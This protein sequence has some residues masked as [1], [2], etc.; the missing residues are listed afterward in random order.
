MEGGPD[1]PLPYVDN[2]RGAYT[3]NASERIGENA[4]EYRDKATP[5][6]PTH[7]LPTTTSRLST[8]L[9]ICHAIDT[10]IYKLLTQQAR[11]DLGG[12]PGGLDGVGL[13]PH[14]AGEAPR[15]QDRHETRG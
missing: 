7:Y 3:S 15:A 4:L 5:L 11:R 6:G 14:P 1:D 13:L 12:G 9:A 2:L 8:D 10:S